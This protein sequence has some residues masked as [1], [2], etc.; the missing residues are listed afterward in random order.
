MPYLLGQFFG[1]VATVACIIVPLFRK[2][3]QMLLNT[4]LVNL[5]MILNLVLLGEV[6]SAVC[7][8]A[9]AIVQCMVSLVHDRRRTAPGP[10][11]TVLFLLLYLGFGFFGMVTAPG[12]VW[13]INGRN[14]LELL[15]ILGSLLSMTFVFVREEQRAR[16]FLLATCSVW[17]LY[18]AIIGSTTFFAELFT[19]LTTVAALRRGRKQHAV[20]AQ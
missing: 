19:V 17:A 14:L 4:A 20:S 7:L 11:E 10:M 6:G 16:W 1:L 2:K 12:F 3:W 13:G 9:V 8:C 5:M 15:P 18:T